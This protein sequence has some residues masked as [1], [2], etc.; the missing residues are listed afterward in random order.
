[1]AVMTVTGPVEAGELGTVLAHEHLFID[2]RNQFTPFDDPE[3][4]RV[5]RQSVGAGN[6]EWL[7]R[8]PYAV[9]DNLVLDDG[10]LTVDELMPFKA[11]G[12]RTVVDCTSIG[13]HRDAAKLEA[14]A[15]QTGLQIVAGCGYY[16]QDTH[17]PDVA[18]RS[19]EELAEGMCRD[20]E[21]GID[22]SGVRAGII[23]EIGTSHPVHPDERKV[24]EASAVAFG[25]VPAAIYVHVY[26]WCTAGLA[27][28]DLLIDRGVPPGRIVICHSDVE[29]DEPYILELL[30][31]GVFVEFDNFG[32]EFQPD[33][34]ERGFAGGMFVSDRARIEL[35]KKLFDRGHGQQLLITN[36]ICLKSMLHACGGL[37]YDHIVTN[38]VPMLRQ[39]GFGEKDIGALLRESPARLLAG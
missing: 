28:A 4:D 26:P 23:G 15:R 22:G 11:A 29:P 6:L 8:N 31:R 20:L 34:D 9:R 25:R 18:A 30:R 14:V 17:P 3:R 36:D 38:V 2:L 24:L 35:L 7:R 39:E 16:T 1:M 19:V 33:A 21:E 5:S 13:I 10:D 12:G 32:K 37:G 27:A